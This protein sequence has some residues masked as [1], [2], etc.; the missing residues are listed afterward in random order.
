M[1]TYLIALAAGFAA[2]LLWAVFVFYGTVNGWGREKLASPGNTE[3][4]LKA[5]IQKIAREAPGNAAFRLIEGGKIAGEHYTTAVTSETLFPVASL[6]KWI[7]AWGV[8]TLVDAG[9]L[10]LDAPVAAYLTRWKLPESEFDNQAV[11]VRRLLSHTAGLTDGLG[12]AG[13]PSGA[14]VQSLEESL[15]RAADADPG[16]DGRVRVGIAPGSK[17]RYSGGGYTL[18]QL[19]V[20]E[21]TGEAFESYVQRTVLQPLGMNRSTFA[22]DPETTS[23]LAAIQTADGTNTPH[24]R[25]T[26]LA[27]TSFYTTAEDLT[28]FVLAHLPGPGGQPIGR[29]VLKPE[30]VTLMRKPHASVLGADMWGLGTMLYVPNGQGDFIIGHDG[31]NEPAINASARLNPGNGDSIILLETGKPL[32]ATTIAGEWVFWQT[33]AIDFLMFT[34]ASKQMFVVILAG[35]ILIVLAAVIL[36]WRKRRVH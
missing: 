17:W 29:G 1:R 28:L 8:M 11:T 30:T 7:A 4:F 2:M 15:A 25:F 18:L 35:W 32:L 13:F 5:A 10:D 22:I 31:K 6:S 19:L 36:V 24:R 20:E 12:Y 33:G 23:N 3:A 16:R 27:A 34:L 21:V 26:A 9:K 14:K